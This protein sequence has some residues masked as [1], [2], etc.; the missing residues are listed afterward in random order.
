M[1][2]RHRRHPGRWQHLLHAARHDPQTHAAMHAWLHEF[3]ARVFYGI[4]EGWAWRRGRQSLRARLTWVFVLLA[5]LAVL[6]WQ[7]VPA[8]PLRI[9]GS[10][11][12]VLAAH[13]VLRRMLLPLWVL[14]LGVA[15]FGRGDLKHRI[16]VRRRDEIGALAARFNQMADDLGG[17]LDAKRAL[18]L[19]ISHELRSPI[20]RA[21]LNLE[22]L[23]DTPQREALVQ[24]LALMRDLIEGLLERERLDAGHSALLL[25]PADWPAWVG[26]VIERRFAAARIQVEIAGDL[27]PMQ[28]DRMR[29]QLLMGNLL[30]NALRHNEPA[31]GQVQL[32]VAAG[33]RGVDLCVRDFGA[34]VPEEA[35]AQLGQPFFRPDASR[36]RA[37]GGVGL[38]LSLCRLIAEAHGADLD[39]ANAA[40]GLAVCVRFPT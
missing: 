7:C 23:E 11:A 6:L 4:D 25:Q 14:G 18:L 21:R 26:E 39:I 12:L 17:M 28:L 10:V 20:T 16:P 33:A 35:L 9:A 19:A 5:L 3:E 29:I 37:S 36:S 34:G 32:T 8:W 27:P 13:L 38:G 22:L 2:G 1:R 24:D 31:N 30:D 40:P 15:A